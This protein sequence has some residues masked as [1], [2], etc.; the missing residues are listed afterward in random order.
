[1]SAGIAN[2]ETRPAGHGLVVGNDLDACAPES[3]LSRSEIGDRVTN[4]PLAQ[5]S[6]FQVLDRKM[7]L[8]WSKLV[9]RT[10][11]PARRLRLRHFLQTHHLAIKVLRCFLERLRHGDVD[12]M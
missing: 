11:A 3:F 4:V 9:P 2:I 8:C 10:T 1:M 5:R 7:E 12:V 6:A